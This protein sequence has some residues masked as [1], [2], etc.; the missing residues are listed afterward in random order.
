MRWVVLAPVMLSASWWGRG[1][2]VIPSP[3]LPCLYMLEGVDGYYE[4]S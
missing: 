4:R 2:I 1:S 3:I